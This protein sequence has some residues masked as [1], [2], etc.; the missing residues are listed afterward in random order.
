MRYL[1]YRIQL[2]EFYF[3]RILILVISFSFF[4]LQI[5]KSKGTVMDFAKPCSK[6]FYGQHLSDTVYLM[7]HPKKHVKPTICEPTLTI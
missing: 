2:M 3:T 4:Q 5:L 1:Y 7:Y 6:T